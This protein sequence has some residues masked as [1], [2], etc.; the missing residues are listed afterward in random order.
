MSEPSPAD[1]DAFS[2]FLVV[3]MRCARLRVQLLQ[4]EIDE[5]GLALR[6]KLIS[7][8]DAVRWLRD[9]DAARFIDWPKETA[10][11]GN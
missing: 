11:D 5:V 8:D 2:E 3:A 10:P 6:H 1:A 7:A 9:I 4:N